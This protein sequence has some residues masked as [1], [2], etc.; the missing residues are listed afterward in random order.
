MIGRSLVV[1][2]STG[3]LGTAVVAQATLDGWKVTG[4]S[5]SEAEPCD[6]GD[7]DEVRHRIERATPDLVVHCA[8]WTDVDGCELD[9]A[10]AE[11]MNV[12]AT[13]N[14]AGPAH[15]VGAHVVYLSTDYV[16]DGAKADPYVE[17]DPTGPLSAY[18]RSK[19]AGEGE[20]PPRS[21]IVRTSWLAGRRGRNVVRTIL[22]RAATTGPLPFVDDQ[23]GCPTIAE[24]LAPLL[25]RLGTDCFGG[26]VHATNQRAVSWYQFAREVLELAGDDPERAVPVATSDLDPPRPAPRPTNS[27]LAPAALDAAGYPRLPD[28]LDSLRAL[29]DDLRSAG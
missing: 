18:G 22:D 12:G 15:D 4:L 29:V 25:L 1:T 16:Y 2:G 23:V 5:R 10:R 8:A 24:D 17:T 14:V 26:I 9:P 7:A 20:L 27:V 6:L 21:T 3:Q 19:L 11:A 28:H 13:R